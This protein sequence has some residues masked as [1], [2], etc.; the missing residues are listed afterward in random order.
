M[1]SSS[2]KVRQND[3]DKKRGLET[4]MEEEGLKIETETMEKW[5]QSHRE[6]PDLLKGKRRRQQYKV[7]GKWI[8]EKCFSND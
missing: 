5:R 1:A 8:E 2:A 4:K 3:R 7:E 6:Q